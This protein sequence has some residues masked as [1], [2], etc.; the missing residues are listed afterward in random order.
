MKDKILLS[1][2]RCDE[3]IAI[4]ILQIVM[5]GKIDVICVSY[6]KTNIR[7][8]NGKKSTPVVR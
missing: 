1:K 6:S 3:S 2:L 5:I 7:R 8:F 4:I